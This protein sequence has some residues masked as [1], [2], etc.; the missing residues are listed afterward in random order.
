MNLGFKSI[1]LLF[2]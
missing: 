2:A 1:V